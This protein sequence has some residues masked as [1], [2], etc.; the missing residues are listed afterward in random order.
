MEFPKV[1]EEYSVVG[2]SLCQQAS[3]T[4]IEYEKYDFTRKG[5]GF[6]VEFFSLYDEE[7]LGD[8]VDINILK[9]KDGSIYPQISVI[10]KK[11]FAIWDGQ[12]RKGTNDILKLLTVNELTEKQR[13]LIKTVIKVFGEALN[14]MIQENPN[15]ETFKDCMKF[16]GIAQQ[17]K[18]NVEKDSE[19]QI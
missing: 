13:E 12:V 4:I 9:N 14:Q 18:Q 5:A 2:E 7:G 15:N 16:F 3:K 17:Q 6:P 8:I 19:M 11:S 10:G 1:I